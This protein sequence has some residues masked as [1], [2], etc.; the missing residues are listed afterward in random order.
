MHWESLSV[1]WLMGASQSNQIVTSEASK[2]H[3]SVWNSLGWKIVDEKPLRTK[4]HKVRHVLYSVCV[5]SAWFMKLEGRCC[6]VR[7]TREGQR[8]TGNRRVCRWPSAIKTESSPLR[9]HVFNN[10]PRGKLLRWSLQHEIEANS[11]CP[12]GPAQRI[13]LQ[14]HCN[15]VECYIPLT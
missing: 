2:Y 10:R 9:S 7:S 3:I 11:I 8:S 6:P 14:G 1:E 5:H 13:A 4:S 12:L 15:T